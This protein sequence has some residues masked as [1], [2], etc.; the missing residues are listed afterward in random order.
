MKT[1]LFITITFIISTNCAKPN[2]STNKTVTT[3]N[4]KIADHGKTKQQEKI[5]PTP[6]DSDIITIS[7]RKEIIATIDPVM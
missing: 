4:K 2:N 7:P 3:A 6:D 1:S 5:K